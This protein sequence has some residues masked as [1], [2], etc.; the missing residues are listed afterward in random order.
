MEAKNYYKI[1]VQSLNLVASAYEVQ[2]KVLPAFVN[3]PDEIALIYTEAYLIIP[4]IKEENIISKSAI[5]Q[6]KKLDELFKK[7]SENKLIWNHES[8]MNDNIWEKSRELALNILFELGESY[9]KP[10]LYFINWIE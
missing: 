5:N 6:M 8:L 3:I 4:Q 7:M 10:D 9:E 2:N 1:L